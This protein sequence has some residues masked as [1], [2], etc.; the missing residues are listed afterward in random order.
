MAFIIYKSPEDKDVII[1]IGESNPRVTV[2]RREGN[3][4]QFNNP[5]VSGSHAILL[6][7]GGRYFFQDSRSTNGSFLNGERVTATVELAN[8]ARLRCGNFPLQFSVTKPIAGAQPPTAPLPMS[9][10]SGSA[11][12]SSAPKAAA[13]VPAPI[14]Q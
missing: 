2:G 5:T 6:Y 1:E 7:Q 9:G 13:P 12:L 10:I 3:T 11:P 8:G 14:L 4:I